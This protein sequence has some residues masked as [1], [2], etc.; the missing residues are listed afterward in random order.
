M[1][2]RFSWRL[3]RFLHAVSDTTAVRFFRL[4]RTPAK[5]LLSLQDIVLDDSAVALH[6]PYFAS[7]ATGIPAL[8]FQTWK[9]R[10][11]IPVNYRYWRQTFVDLNPEAVVVLWDDDDNRRFIAER[12][13]WFL[14]VY[15]SYPREIFRADAVR[16]FFL[17]EFGGLYAD[18]DSECLRPLRLS[19]RTNDILLGWMGTNK[20]FEHALPNAIMASRPRQLFWLLAILKM[21]EVAR[22]NPDA[23]KRNA[24][25]PEEMTGPIL[26]KRT[27]HEFASL[28]EEAAW[29]RVG[30][31]LD[32]L[33]PARRSSVNYGQVTTLGRRIWY[34]LDWTN[35]IHKKLRNRLRGDRLFLSPAQARELFPEAE[36]V[37]YW[38][39]SW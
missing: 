39:H 11:D 7:V 37:T 26:L 34:P 30:P 2:D 6:I 5:D 15:D 21:I 32:L 8:V 36:I 17:F 31:V 14:A 29:H 18:M 9:S 28:S 19:M 1:P 33:D 20:A 24:L 23:A 22:E 16:F 27:Y 12:Y 4:S 25:G 38:S 13:P 10:S 35:F 3:R